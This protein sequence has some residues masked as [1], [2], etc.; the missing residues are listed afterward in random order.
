MKEG[1]IVPHIPHVPKMPQ[2]FTFVNRLQWGLA[3]VMAGP[4]TEASFRRISEDWI[5]GGM[6][7]IPK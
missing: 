2:D 1:D 3:S 6:S 4:G 5:R 7:P